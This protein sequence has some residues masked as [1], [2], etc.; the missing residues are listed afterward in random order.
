MRYIETANIEVGTFPMPTAKKETITLSK[1]DFM[2]QLESFLAKNMDKEQIKDEVG[3]NTEDTVNPEKLEEKEDKLD[4]VSPHHLLNFT[5]VDQLTTDKKNQ[6]NMDDLIS[7]KKLVKTVRN[8]QEIKNSAS[9]EILLSEEDYLVKKQVESKIEN[10]ISQLP[11]NEKKEIITTILNGISKDS[12]SMLNKKIR[13]YLKKYANE[14]IQTETIMDFSEVPGTQE[15]INIIV[16]EFDPLRKSEL[17]ESFIQKSKNEPSSAKVGVSESKG[18]TKTFEQINPELTSGFSREMGAKFFSERVEVNKA[19]ES[20]THQLVS[21]LIR[22]KE[23]ELDPDL[24]PSENKNQVKILE[25]L[26]EIFPEVIT[27]ETLSEIIEPNLQS[28]ISNS[29]GD[30]ESK[31]IS[32]VLVNMITSENIELL[33]Q[34]L[35]EIITKMGGGRKS[36]EGLAQIEKRSEVSWGPFIDKTTPTTKE[37]LVSENQWQKMTIESTEMSVEEKRFTASIKNPEIKLKDVVGSNKQTEI[38]NE[39]NGTLLQSSSD[40]FITL[41]RLPMNHQITHSEKIVKQQN[42]SSY[43]EQLI[44]EETAVESK[45]NGVTTAH[46]QL[47]PDRLGKVDLHL[48]MI[49]KELTAK[50]LVEKA[51]TKEWIEQQI[52]HLK[53][54]LHSQEIIIKDFQ[55]V[56]HKDTLNDAFMNSDENP[57]FKQK[58]KDSQAKKEQSGFKNKETELPIQLEDRSYS[59]RNGISILV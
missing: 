50:L 57:F 36:A 13:E 54:K 42:F 1:K 18:F 58:E 29:A 48:E 27:S 51:D 3:K 40:Q 38:T 41:N 2:E 5:Q 53:E 14:A 20:N 30:E 11:K 49:D 45:T 47:S 23:L 16:S 59:T 7:E 37:N 12:K 34:A 22:D 28:F 6:E 31:I 44:I 15:I 25:E 26:A 4:F 8:T 33:P 19:S 52:I 46:M 56:V 35:Q 10:I 55:V 17:A 24:K 39:R 9:K 32:K 21:K 43:V